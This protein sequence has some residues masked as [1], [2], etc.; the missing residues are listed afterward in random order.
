MEVSEF[1][2]LAEEFDA[3]VRRIAWCTVATV[4]PDGAPWTR[5][6]HPIWEAETGW[7]ATTRH[8][9]KARHIEHEPRVSLTYWDAEHDVVTVRGVGRRPAAQGPHLGALPRD[10]SAAGL[11]PGPVLAEPDQPRVRPA[12]DRSDPGRGHRPGVVTQTEAGLAPPAVT[13]RGHTR[14]RSRR[15]ATRGSGISA[16]TRSAYERHTAPNEAR[17]SRSSMAMPTRM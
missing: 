11:R 13:V 14:S 8:S 4:A 10:P 1:G 12:P 3:R 16:G 17:R 6:L 2:Q 7:I 15:P 5:I 9:P